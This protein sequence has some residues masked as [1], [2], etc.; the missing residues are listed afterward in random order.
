MGTRGYQDSSPARH[1][2]WKASARHDRLQEKI[3]EPSEQEKVV[4]ILEADGFADN[5]ADQDFERA[6]ETLASLAT[7]L[8]SHNYAVGLLSN[9]DINGNG[10]IEKAHGRVLRPGRLPG[11]LPRLLELLARV[12]MRKT[13]GMGGLMQETGNI[14]TGAACV[15]FSYRG[16]EAVELLHR[17]KTPVVNVTAKEDPDRGGFASALVRSY[18]LDDLCLEDSHA[19]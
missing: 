3:F 15:C 9:C 2:H 10:G 19:G 4:L 11:Q 7:L 6:V 16:G 14:P 5:Q 8:D 1:I 13:C 12:G 17:R 18:L